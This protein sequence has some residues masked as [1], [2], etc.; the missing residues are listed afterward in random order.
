MRNILRDD[1]RIGARPLGQRQAD[2]GNALP[3]ALAVARIVPD[4]VL[5]RVRPDDDG[6]DVLDVDRPSVPRRNQQQAD[7]GNSRERLPGRDAANDSG[8][9][10]LSGQERTIGVL[11]LGDELLQR[12]AEQRQLL[13]IRLDPDLLGGA[14][15]D[16]GQPDAVDL[17]QFGAQFVGEFVEILVRPA[18]GG[19]GLRRKRE[20]GDGD[21]VD[22]APDDQGLGNADRNAVQIGAD[23]LVNAQDRV[24]GLGADQKA[25]G[26]HHAV[27]FGLAVD[28]LHP[29]DALDDGLQRLGDEFDRVGPAQSVGV[30]A[31]IDHGNADLRLFLAR[32]DDDGDQADDKRRRAGTAASAANRWSPG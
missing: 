9:A 15:G 7:I 17:H 29:V 18:I 20:H 4:P 23:L 21:V 5:G 24:V 6:G 2:R 30:D 26:H 31:D 8:V 22:A 13:R 19:F 11:H 27:V 3:L 14:A 10:D 12:D 16:V 25:R 28:V 1:H 32:N